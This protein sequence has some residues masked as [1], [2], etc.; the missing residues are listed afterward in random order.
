MYSIREMSPRLPLIS[1]AVSLV[2]RNLSCSKIDLYTLLVV[3][4]PAASLEVYD[5]C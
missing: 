2:N 5:G 1:S 3:F 4:F